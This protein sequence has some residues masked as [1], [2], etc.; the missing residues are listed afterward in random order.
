MVLVGMV[1]TVIESSDVF[2]GAFGNRFKCFN[3]YFQSA[4]DPLHSSNLRRFNGSSDDD[5]D[6]DECDNDGIPSFS[7]D[8]GRPS[9]SRRTA[10]RRAILSWSLN[11][12]NRV[13]FE[14][15][16]ILR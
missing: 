10:R 15:H 14:R 3:T 16:T 2:N 12:E 8:N 1:V 7:Y 9:N 5:N 13:H 6:D 4:S 11:L